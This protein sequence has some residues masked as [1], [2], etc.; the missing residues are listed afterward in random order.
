MPSCFFH[1]G[2]PAHEVELREIPGNNQ[3]RAKDWQVRWLCDLCFNALST[4]AGRKQRG[5][6]TWWQART[7]DVRAY[8][9]A[10][11]KKLGK[12]T[13]IGD[14]ARFKRKRGL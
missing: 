11:Q 10:K 14:A 7:R 3:F 12:I 4:G 5:V 9:T 2:K 8:S 1:H 6:D 13:R